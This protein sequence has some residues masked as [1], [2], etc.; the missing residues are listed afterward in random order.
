MPHTLLVDGGGSLTRKDFARVL[1]DQVNLGSMVELGYDATTVGLYDLYMGV[2]Y[3]RE[4]FGESGLRVVSANVHDESTGEL[5]VEP[6]AIIEKAGVTF[7]VTGVLDQGTRI[8]INRGLESPGVTVGSPG[9]ALLELL[10][11]L[12]KKCDHVVVLAHMSLKLAK[13]LAEQVPGIDYLVV[14]LQAQKSSQ[15]FEV[16]G[17]VFLQPGNRG[18]YMADYRLMYS[19]EGVFQEYEGNV[20]ELGDKVPAD[21]SMALKL[22]EHKIAV[23]ELNKERAAAMAREREASLK[24][25]EA[26]A[27][28]CLGVEA[29]CV[30]CHSDQYE[31]WKT[32]THAHAY[33]TL[34]QAFQ[35]TNPECLRCHTTCQLELKQDGSAVVPEGLRNVQCESCHGIGTEHARDGSYGVIRVETC[36]GCHDED[37]SPDF[38]LATYLPKV[39]H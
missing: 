33:Q 10:P 34:Q 38:D 23:E 25:A 35:S 9:D 13:G 7:G 39:T 5:L 17:A 21:A 16:E 4:R 29:S 37:N 19:E 22:K 20:V 1:T 27:P 30:R 6:Y 31:Q 18:Q 2:E 26:Y 3:F 36:L 24:E 28:A 11:E 15:P 12:E 32:S 14:G 8:R